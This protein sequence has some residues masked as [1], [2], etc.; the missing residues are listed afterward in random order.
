MGK[1]IRKKHLGKSKWFR[2]RKDKKVYQGAHGQGR[3]AHQGRDMG[4]DMRVRTIV[5]VEQSPNGELARRMKERLRSME[6]THGFRVKVVER[7]GQQLG[8]KFLLSTLW[9]GTKCGRSDCVICEQGLRSSPHV[10]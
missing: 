3:G 8:S 10:L 9:D 2:K 1:R 5:F 6:E 7:V 4:G